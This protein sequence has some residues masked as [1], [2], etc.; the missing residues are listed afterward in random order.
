MDLKSLKKYNLMLEASCIWLPD[1]KKLLNSVTHQEH[2]VTYVQK[3]YLLHKLVNYNINGNIYNSIKAIYDNPVSCVQLGNTLSDWFPISSG[4]RQGD[5][6]SPV[7][8]ATFINDLAAEINSIDAGV[9]INGN[10]LR[11]LM[12]ADNIVLISGGLDEAPEQLDVMKRWCSRWGMSVN[13]KKSQILH[14]RNHQK[15]K[16]K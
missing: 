15:P 12:Y 2:T 16:N 4:V 5:S 8:F 3:E 11:L 14:I 1:C 9:D 13:S 7:L 6:L 10:K